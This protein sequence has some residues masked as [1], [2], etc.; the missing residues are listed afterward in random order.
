M[1]DPER[2]R[3]KAEVEHW[4]TRDPVTVLPARLRAAGLADDA[5]LDRIEAEVAD[6]IDAAVQ[7]AEQAPLEEVA[8]LTRFV[9]SEDGTR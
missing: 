5:A 7:A 2:Y 9:M 1:Y 4:K 3:D 6:E 8:D